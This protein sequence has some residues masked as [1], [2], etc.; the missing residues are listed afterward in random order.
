MK[1]ITTVVIGLVVGLLAVAL[2]RITETTIVW[3]NTLLRSI[4]HSPDY[5][6]EWGMCL[7]ALFHVSYSVLLVIIGSSLVCPTCGRLEAYLHVLLLVLKLTGWLRDALSLLLAI[8]RCSTAHNSQTAQEFPSSWHT[9][10]GTASQTCCRSGQILTVPAPMRQHQL[11]P[12]ENAYSLSS[13]QER[14]RLSGSAGR[15]LLSLWAPAAGSAPMSR[16]GQRHLLYTLAH[17]WQTTS[18]T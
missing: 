2:G 7:A 5:S 8:Y 12:C 15:C 17:V 13:C 6:I 18:H 1:C 10:T 11:T 16:W 14:A 3:K 4:V 9:L